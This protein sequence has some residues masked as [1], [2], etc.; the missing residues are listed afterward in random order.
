MV[1]SMG[2]ISEPRGT[3]G[4]RSSAAGAAGIIYVASGESWGT[5]RLSSE[6]YLKV[7]HGEG[8]GLAR[9]WDHRDR[10]GVGD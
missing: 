4:G 7:V 1:A 10:P 2:S 3:P 9:I 6:R 8:V 5:R